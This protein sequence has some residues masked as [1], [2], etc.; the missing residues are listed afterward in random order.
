MR[1]F[2]ARITRLAAREDGQIAAQIVGALPAA[3]APG[4][5]YLAHGV[6]IAGQYLRLPLFPETSGPDRMA[7]DLPPDLAGLQPGDE[8][9]LIGPC[10]RGLALPDHARN[11][12]L[13]A[14]TAGAAR[15]RPIAHA[16]LARRCSV[17]LL[18][19]TPQPL[20]DLPLEIEVRMGTSDLADALAWADALCA[21]LVP[22]SLGDLQRQLRDNAADGGQMAAPWAQAFCLPPVPCGVGACGACAVP[23]TGGWRFAC[24]DGPWFDLPGL[25]L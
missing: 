11:V 6:G 14:G 4:Q 16:A 15:L 17:V 9:D 13:M 12:L 2:T 24:V 19:Q 20:A 25:E 1:Q 23:T 18:C 8:L 3:H 10:G 22:A 5:F 7:L 21:H